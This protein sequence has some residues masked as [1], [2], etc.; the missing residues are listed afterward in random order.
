[1]TDT[2]A[3][4][5]QEDEKDEEDEIEEGRTREGG[6]YRRGTRNGGGRDTGRGANREEEAHVHSAT[7]RSTPRST[8]A[9]VPTPRQPNLPPARQSDASD[10][11][12]NESLPSSQFRF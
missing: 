2:R 12:A 5:I 8:T 6:R 10:P 1:M 7:V 9:T 11:F 3:R 4:S